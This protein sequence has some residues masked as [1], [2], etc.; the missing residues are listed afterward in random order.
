MPKVLLVYA[1][2]PSLPDL[3]QEDL[4]P[5]THHWKNMNQHSISKFIAPGPRLPGGQPPEGRPSIGG[6][7]HVVIH[8][9]GPSLLSSPSAAMHRPSFHLCAS[10]HSPL[11]D[12]SIFGAQI[13]VLSPTAM[14]FPGVP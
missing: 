3:S 12:N 2:S 4:G 14:V 7:H 9:T 8:I 13:C 11:Y 10:R 6:I 1:E 5:V